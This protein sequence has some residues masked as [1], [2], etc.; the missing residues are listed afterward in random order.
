MYDS[1]VAHHCACMVNIVKD[2]DL[3]CYDD[4]I[5]NVEWEKSMV[6]DANE[7]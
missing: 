1:Y 2:V 7:T 5:G 3:S 6:V 4:A